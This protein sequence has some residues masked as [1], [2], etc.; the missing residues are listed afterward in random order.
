[1]IDQKHLASRALGIAGAIADMA[2]IPIVGK[3][4]EGLAAMLDADDAETERKHLLSIQR[5]ISDEIARREAN[6]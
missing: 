2:G 3:V 4:T 6:E 1:M 5:A